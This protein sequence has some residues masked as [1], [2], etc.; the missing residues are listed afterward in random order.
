M[1]KKK[2]IAILFFV[3]IFVIFYCLSL[4]SYAAFEGTDVTGEWLT[5]EY[6]EW[7]TRTT[8]D[9]R[10]Y[11]GEHIEFDGDK[12][13]FYGYDSTSYKDFFIKSIQIWEKRAFLLQWMIA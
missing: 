2:K 12:V 13:T 9:D 11:N 10:A 8:T 5:P 7:H 4:N 6:W 1:N 3:I